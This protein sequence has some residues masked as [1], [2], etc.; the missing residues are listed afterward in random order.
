MSISNGAAAARE[1][2]RHNDGK[3]GEQVHGEP[4]LS[5]APARNWG[6]VENIQ[7]G[8][9]TP[10]GPAQD[11]THHADGIVFAG[12]VGHGGFKLS[13]ERNKAIPA[14]LRRKGG[15]YEEDSEAHIVAMYFPEETRPSPQ[16]GYTV[17]KDLD[18]WIEYSRGRVRNWHP[19][20]YEAATGETIE[21][22]QSDERDRNNWLKAHEDDWVGSGAQ[23]QDDG[24]VLV[25]ARRNGEE[26]RFIV[27]KDVYDA[28]GSNTEPGAGNM[29]VVPAGSQE[30]APEPPKTPAT[31]HTGLN[32]S[33]LTLRQLQVA[34]KELARRYQK[35]DSPVRT[36]ADIIT[37]EGITGKSVTVTN[38]KRE[39]QLKAKDNVEDSSYYAY[40]VSAALFKAVEAPDERTA[41]DLAREKK[42][43]ADHRFRTAQSFD[44]RRKAKAEWLAAE[45]E[46]LAVL[47]AEKKAQEQ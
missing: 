25:W 20:E 1:N 40:P 15:W 43:I 18:E 10:W 44:E 37:K 3:F 47:K 35:P 23:T 42:D 19:D 28:R 21:P 39:Y 30:A 32:L 29:F 27:P 33:S 13:A 24:T 8:S 14:P 41:R 26:K 16:Y 45:D 6:S 36:L 11:V 5:L 4:E 34:T 7:E 22:G 9:R 2:A 12:T 46:Y 38:G 31:R 17:D